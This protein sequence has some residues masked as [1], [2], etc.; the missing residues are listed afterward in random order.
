MYRDS[1]YEKIIGPVKESPMSQKE[2]YKRL[3]PIIKYT[4]KRKK[5]IGIV[6][7]AHYL[8]KGVDEGRVLYLGN[9]V[10][11][12]DARYFLRYKFERKWPFYGW[13]CYVY[14]PKTE[15]FYS[16]IK[17]LSKDPKLIGDITQ[18]YRVIEFASMFQEIEYYN[19]KI[20]KRWKKHKKTYTTD[21]E[22]KQ[23]F[24]KKEKEINKFYSDKYRK[25]KFMDLL[26][27]TPLMFWCAFKR[28]VPIEHPE[29]VL[30]KDLVE[31]A[32]KPLIKKISILL[33]HS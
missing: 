31:I 4:M 1:Y 20:V 25:D 33:K 11:K 27:F 7:I 14:T 3:N 6:G 21:E 32:T 13:Q 18:L 29:Y 22:V 26:Q 30:E 2:I 19:F 12:K 15:K 10:S 17:N 16:K 23:S 28:V 9:K 24:I 5:N 8:S